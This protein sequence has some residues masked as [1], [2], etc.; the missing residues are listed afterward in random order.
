MG[1]VEA[2][3]RGS[4]APGHLRQ[5]EVTMPPVEQRL[6]WMIDALIDPSRVTAEE[7][8]AAFDAADWND[9]SPEREL[10]FLRTGPHAASRPFTVESTSLETAVHATAVLVGAD[11]KRW[12]VSCW[13]QDD[14]PYL[15]NGARTMPAPPAGTTIRLAE[16][17]DAAA[18]ADLERH[19]PLRLGR[20]PLTLMSFDHGDDYFARSRLM[21][22][23][24]TYVAEVGGAVAGVY[25]GTVQSVLL[26]G[27]PKQLFLEHRVRIDPATARGG[28]F[29]A[30][31]QYGRDTYARSTDSIAFYVSVDNHPVRKFV[32]GVP[33]WSVRPLRALLPCPS[34]AGG[35]ERP[36]GRPASSGDAGEVARI[37]NAAHTGSALFVPYDES[38]LRGRLER[39]PTQYGWGDVHLAPS[40]AVV[41]VSQAMVTVTKECAGAA[42]VSRRAL[43]LDHGFVPGAEAVYRDLLIERCGQLADLGATH[44]AVFTSERSS[45]HDVVMSLAES[46]EEFDFWAFDLEEPAALADRGFYVDPVYF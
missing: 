10:E 22:E 17:G 35:A 29:W 46:V 24:T 31:C 36:V 38:S 44:L 7:I 20:E 27:E 11:G 18:L 40:G 32:E 23:E 3:E 9:W 16:A 15:I 2:E 26:D 5:R 30:L 45:T 25:C 28:V 1:E 33:P 37:L 8:G 42:V 19:A 43:A 34:T 12:S 13:I 6:T 41:G 4:V 39:D 14:A 21:A